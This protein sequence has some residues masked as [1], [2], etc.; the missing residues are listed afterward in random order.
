VT[1]LEPASTPRVGPRVICHMMTSVDGRI[2]VAGWPLSSTARQ[3][4]EQVHARYN[5]NGWMCGRIT[6]EHFAK[7]LRTDDAVAH[8]YDRETPRDDYIAP[9]GHATFAFAMDPRGRLAWASNEIDGDHVVAIVSQ[10][11]SDE[12]LAFLRDRGVSYLIAGAVDLDL[13]E[14]L[15]KIG[16][17]FAVKTL[18][19]EGGGRIN[20][21]MMRAG[22]IDEV[23]L[24][25]APIA[26][27]RLGMPALFDAVGAPQ[28]L[29]LIGVEQRADDMLWIR[30]RVTDRR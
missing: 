11:V 18:L 12:Y 21:A 9:R 16:T 23:S 8:E 27:G 25:V 30:Y 17:R 7:A 26:D 22:L 6:M 13:H 20:G 28:G 10:R 14:A 19:V 4:Y 24:L 3:H 2:G 1:Q 15:H 5:A 29:T